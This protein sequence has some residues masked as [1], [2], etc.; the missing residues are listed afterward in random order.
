MPGTFPMNRRLV[1]AVGMLVGTLV[2][3]LLTFTG[4]TND[5]YAHLALAQQMLLGDRPI[6]D[7]TDPGWPLTYMISAA[8]WRLA[9]SAMWV[10]WTITAGAFACAAA[11]TVAAAQRLS[12]SVA[13]AVLVTAIQVLISPRTYAYPKLLPYAAFAC[14]IVQSGALS[15]R[16]LALLGL[17]IGAAFLLRHDHGL[18]IGLATLAYLALSTPSLR[19][20]ALATRISIVAATTALLLLPWLLFVAANG[21]LVSYFATAIEYA[22]A[23]ANFS[24]LRSLPWFRM[25][26]DDSAIAALVSGPNADAWLFWLFWALPVA[27]AAIVARRWRRRAERWPG[28]LAAVGALCVLAA[29][30]N[31]G[32]LRDILRTRFGDATA[33]AALLGA[34]L[35]GVAWTGPWRLRAAQRIVQL[36]AALGIVV[37]FIAVGHVADLGDRFERTNIGAGPTGVAERFLQHVRL[38]QLPHRQELMPPSRT[39]AVLMPFFA[40]LDRCTIATD[41]LI[42]TGEFP[43]VVVLSGRGFAS[44]GV[45]FGAWYSSTANQ[46]RTLERLRG[47]P[48]L[49]VVAADD[50]A[51]FHRWFPLVARFVDEEYAPFAALGGEGVHVPV[52]VDRRRRPARVDAETGWPCYR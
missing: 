45:V 49:F 35:L 42:V 39:S 13:I 48:A 37:S 4:F 36:T 34:W 14:L 40:Y 31:A 16:R 32:F 15:R 11:F 50:P 52:L 24:M 10:E 23:E 46:P 30:V 28:E 33:P 6:R 9:G 51:R 25:P 7:F 18:W 20:R 2:W 41:R 44:D 22:R 3:R 47:H 5:H 12:G 38:L 21:G 27:G 17:L 19:D 43:D 1:A 8:A 26:S 29:T